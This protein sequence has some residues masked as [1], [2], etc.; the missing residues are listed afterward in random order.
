MEITDVYFEE[1]GLRLAELI[2]DG[3]WQVIKINLL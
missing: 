3:S 2:D 1:L